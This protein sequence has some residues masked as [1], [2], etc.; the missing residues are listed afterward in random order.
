MV[1]LREALVAIVGPENG[2]PCVATVGAS[3]G[4]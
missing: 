2:G 1:A 3:H 4:P